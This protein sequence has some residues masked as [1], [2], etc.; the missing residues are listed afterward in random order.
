MQNY[1][2]CFIHASDLHLDTVFS[3]LSKDI[4]SNLATILHNST[5]VA[6]NRLIQL[7][8]THHPD[9]L[10][11]SGDIYNEEDYSIRAIL[12]LRDGCYTLEK[13]GIQVFI[14]HGNHDPYSSRMKSIT[15]P[16]NVTIFDTEV[17]SVPY[18]AKDGTLL[19]R[20]YGISHASN[21]ESKNLALQFHRTEDTCLHIAML[22]CTVGSPQHY[23][24]YAPCSTKNL[25]DAG[26]DYWALGHVHE[27]QEISQDP[28]IVYPGC[29]QGLH[30]HEQGEK[31]CVLVTTKQQGS[32]LT[33]YKKF[34]TLGPVLWHT[35]TIQLGDTNQPTLQE[36]ISNTLSLDYIED[37]F[38]NALN[39]LIATFTPGWQMLILRLSFTGC[40]SLD[41][42]LRYGNNLND[43]LERLR[44][45]ASSSQPVWIK[46]IQLL[47]TSPK[48]YHELLEREDL[49]GEVV[50]LS[51]SINELENIE[52]IHTTALAPLFSH[53]KL[54]KI[55]NYP[56][57]LE[58]KQLL[59]EAERLCVELLENN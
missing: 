40:T 27:Y 6:F 24:R 9:F 17:T 56:N 15:W 36:D 11:L 2:L 45:V 12:T 1:P 32:K 3:G 14:V 59:T 44:D 38:H 52:Q 49:L 41:P 42:L 54:R 20:I 31:G 57:Q 8:I 7:C 13:E 47:T 35:L 34:Y 25:I 21:K 50:R 29:T 51:K 5:F 18:T 19:A 53:H 10:L 30:I 58:F 33:L 26:M 4:P 23:D 55:L 39:E 43:L 48:Y 46:D 22:H 16:K 28:L 37:T